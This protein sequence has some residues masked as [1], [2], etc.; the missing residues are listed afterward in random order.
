MTDVSATAQLLIGAGILFVG[1]FAMLV[2]GNNTPDLD[3]IGW[4]VWGL[5][6]MGLGAALAVVA[7]AVYAIGRLRAGKA[8]E[9]DPLD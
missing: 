3:A 2:K 6:V 7:A 8:T 9:L 1:G 4:F 5:L